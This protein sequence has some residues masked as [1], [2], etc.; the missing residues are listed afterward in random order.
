MTNSQLTPIEFM[1]AE[2]T[3]REKAFVKEFETN[4]MVD[5]ILPN[6]SI[7]YMVFKHVY[8]RFSGKID[9]PINTSCFEEDGFP[10]PGPTTKPWKDRIYDVA[11]IVSSLRR[12]V[13][14]PDIAAR[15]T[16]KLNARATGSP[17]KVL[18]VGD[19]KTADLGLDFGPCE[20][21]KRMDHSDLMAML[22]DVK[23]VLMTSRFDASPNLLT[24]AVSAG[25]IPILTTNVGNVEIVDPFFVISSY[26]EVDEWV[27]KLEEILKEETMHDRPHR[28]DQPFE[29]LSVKLMTYM[30]QL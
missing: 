10:G 29:P 15:I 1:S 27:L 16:F 19:G 21:K 2:R 7:S 22:Q 9:D 4:G 20:R 23:C 12:E 14:G 24:E 30:Q 11:F 17:F 26:Y 13:K 18:V 8:G 5:R 3:N 6:S 25:C 28:R